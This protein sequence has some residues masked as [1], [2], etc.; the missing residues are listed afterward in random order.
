MSDLFKISTDSYGST[1]NINA[2]MI[3]AGILT[4]DGYSSGVLNIDGYGNIDTE[5]FVSYSGSSSRTSSPA[6]VDVT[7]Q[8]DYVNYGGIY[9][10]V[11]YCKDAFGVVHL[12]GIAKNGT[13][14][15]AVFNLPSGSR[16]AYEYVFPAI[17]DE[18]YGNSIH[19]EA[20]GDVRASNGGNID[21]VFDGIVFFAEQ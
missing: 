1:V 19:V 7:F 4:I 20:N 5:G 3:L 16:A 18:A 21:V 14:G 13:S 6:W 2:D 9:A 12:R 8:N 10:P 11:S 17:I 15:A